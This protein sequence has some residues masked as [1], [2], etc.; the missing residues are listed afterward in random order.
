M[1]TNWLAETQCS[2]D[3]PLLRNWPTIIR[4]LCHTCGK[5]SLKV[6][7]TQYI[8]NIYTTYTKYTQQYNMYPNIIRL[9]W[10]TCGK[11]LLKAEY[12]Q[13]LRWSIKPF[14]LFIDHNCDTRRY[15]AVFARA[16]FK[17]Y[18]FR[19]R[20]KAD[21]YNDETRVKHTVVSVEPVDYPKLCRYN[22]LNELDY[23]ILLVWKG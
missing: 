13:K 14:C 10:R 1:W 6:E 3:R 8:Y 22:I 9:L 23:C 12:T 19:L 16:S 2:L 21:T 17:S 7:Y 5:T 4:L 20:A 11:T 18:A 15:N